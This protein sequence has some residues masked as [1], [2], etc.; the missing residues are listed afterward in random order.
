MLQ[1]IF[2]KQRNGERNKTI[3]PRTIAYSWSEVPAK[4][5]QSKRAA[6]KMKINL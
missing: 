1:L 5:L 2:V 6:G 3:I 4:T